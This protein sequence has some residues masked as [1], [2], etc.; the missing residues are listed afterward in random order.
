MAVSNSACNAT[1]CWENLI[2]HLYQIGG[3]S[4][5]GILYLNTS[6]STVPGVVFM[7]IRDYP[8]NQTIEFSTSTL[9]L[10]A[11]AN[12]T[13]YLLE[14]GL[15]SGMLYQATIF[16]VEPS[17]VAISSTTTIAFLG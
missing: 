5:L 4:A 13:A 15:V 10:A 14:F 16:V 8:M 3:Y 17:G 2:G 12:G 11:G 6:N 9:Q 7:D 1:D